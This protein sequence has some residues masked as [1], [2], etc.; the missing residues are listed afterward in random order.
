MCRA[1]TLKGADANFIADI[2]ST[3]PADDGRRRRNRSIS[4]GFNALITNLTGA[5]AVIDSGGRGDFDSRAANFSG[6]ISGALSLVFNG[7]ASLSGVEDY[8]GGATSRRRGHGR[9]HRH[10]R[11]RRQQRHSGAPA[12]FF[13][14]NGLFEKTGGGGVSDVTSDFVNNGTLNVLSGS[15]QFSGGF[16]NNGVIHGPLSPRAAASGRSP[17]SAP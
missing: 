13:I 17:P 8:T 6:T 3:A 7:N 10:I 1:G 5:G 4:P 15:V 14:N 2:A 16:T 11:H 9:Q 12:S